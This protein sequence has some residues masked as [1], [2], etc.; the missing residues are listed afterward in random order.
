VPDDVYRNP[1]ERRPRRPGGIV[2]AAAILI[3]LYGGLLRFEA[4]SGMY[5]GERQPGWGQAM[6]RQLVPLARALR[7]STVAWHTIPNPYVGGDPVNYIRYAREMTHFYQAHVREPVFLAITK[8]FLWL[9]GGRDIAVSYAS[10]FGGTLAILATFVLGAGA[11]TRAVGLAAAFALAIELQA[12]NWA[13]DGWRDDTFMLFV[14][15]SAWSFLRLQR[16]PSARAGVVAGVASAAASLTRI[17]ALSFII[18]AWLWI[19][20]T[21]RRG[22][23]ENTWKAIG[24]SA[25]VWT[26]LVGPYLANCWRVFGDPLYA[27]NYHARYYRSAEGLALD[28]SV[29]ALEYAGSK[30]V[31]RPI[32]TIDT[33][34]QGLITVPF[35][36]K[37]KGWQH[38]SGAIGSAMKVFGALG[39]I[40]ALWSTPG[41]LLVLILLTSLVPYALTWSLG[42]G[43]E[44]RFT[45]HVY[46]VYLVFACAAI[47]WTVATVRALARRERTV[48]VTRAHVV[49][50]AALA[51]AAM[52]AWGAFT[53]SP[54]L[55]AREALAAGDAVSIT[56]GDRDAWFFD[57]KWSAPID[58]G[59]VVVRVAE[60]EVV[61][62]RLPLADAAYVLTL[63]MDPPLTADPGRQPKL[64]VFLNRRALGEIDLV[65]DPARM[66]SY[67]LQV[68][69]EAVKPVS[70]LEILASHLV[71]VSEAG[72]PF[73]SLAADTPVAFRLWYVRLEPLR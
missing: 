39:T 54:L 30:L 57:G 68:P 7:P 37:W 23:R 59:N 48:R 60:A 65:R 11:Y 36:N 35:E 71:P 66:G 46:P 26:V 5:G 32:S 18:P 58:Y 8:A 38:W 41:R 1:L 45:Q 19:A 69:K 13:A 56:A 55:I 3:T 44:W 40:A 52:L 31:T 29:G 27:I 47:S 21:V 9:T 73:E 64:T 33:A 62:I 6:E 42:G 25:L 22:A 14:T 72:V 49:R 50:A 34:A 16:E 63:R 20:V 70:R 10:V 17:S 4:L 24:V 53:F 61:G 12:I 51:A 15:L 43:G 2:L 28:E 67:R